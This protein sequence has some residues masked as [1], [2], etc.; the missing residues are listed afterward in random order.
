MA[1][2][3]QLI[4][5]H[6]IVKNIHKGIVDLSEMNTGKNTAFQFLRMF[7]WNRILLDLEDADLQV[8]TTD[9]A[10]LFK[11]LKNIFPDGAFIA[12]IQPQKMVFNYC[13]FAKSIA[14]EWTNTKV[15]ILFQEDLAIRWL[16]EQ[17]E[18]L[19]L[20]TS[21]TGKGSQDGLSS[22]WQSFPC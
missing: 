3:N 2:Q 6:H 1:Y 10:M 12:V 21:K 16:T 4:H 11:G 17:S 14:N 5:D 7:G 22:P 18:A 13:K 19:Q 9:V 20:P 8:M 15:E